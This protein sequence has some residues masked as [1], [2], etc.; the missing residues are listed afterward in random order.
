MKKYFCLVLCGFVLFVNTAYCATIGDPIEPIGKGKM[1]V[2]A[3]HNMIYSRETE[4][5]D[6]RQIDLKDAYQWYAKGTYGLHKNINVYGKAGI[7]DI[8]HKILETSAQGGGDFALEWDMGPLWGIG[9][10]AATDRWHGFNAGLD[11]QYV[12]WFCDM[13][14]FKY[15]QDTSSVTTGSLLTTEAQA[16]FFITYEIKLRGSAKFVP[17][18]GVSYLYLNSD[19]TDTIEYS[20]PGK[21]GTMDYD[22]DNSRDWIFVLGGDFV[23]GENFSLTLEGTVQYDNRG[24]MLGMSYKF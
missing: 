4:Y 14:V 17:Y 10:L 18:G 6:Y 13:E 3:A 12:G 2:G 24:V 5:G 15:Q 21:T 22:I 1:M 16:T 9:I 23:A 7:S 19:T 11:L 8:E 20:T